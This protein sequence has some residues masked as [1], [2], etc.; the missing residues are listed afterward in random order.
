MSDV[1]AQLKQLLRQDLTNLNALQSLLGQ[2]QNLL[3]TRDS[4]DI[5]R[6]SENKAS[7]VKQIE[8][9]AKEKARLLA[10]SGWGVKPGQVGET[11]KKLGDE[12][13][14]DLWQET[15]SALQS[16]K[17]KNTVNG[18]IISHTL[19]RTAKLMNIIRGQNKA[20]NL[21]G[22]KGKTSQISGSHILGK[23]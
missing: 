19:Q 20:P 9:H 13:L 11:L 3:K 12:E 22:Q 7:L 8:T 18:T 14:Y 6:I 5:K 1:K 15:V 23:A 4:E 17:D 2:E 10:S 16:C 21:Y